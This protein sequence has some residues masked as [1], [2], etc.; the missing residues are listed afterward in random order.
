[1]ASAV[2]RGRMVSGGAGAVTGRFAAIVEVSDLLRVM[3]DAGEPLVAYL[4]H[5]N[6]TMMAPI[7]DRLAAI[8]CASGD[9]QAHVAIVARELGLPCA[10]QIGLDRPPGELEGHWVCLEHGGTLRLVD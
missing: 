8:V 6:V 1:M 2:G 9:E 4:E 5:P 10:V 7:H 3:D